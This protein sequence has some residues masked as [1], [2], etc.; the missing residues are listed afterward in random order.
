MNINL[1]KVFRLRSSN[2]AVSL[3]VLNCESFE[4]ILYVPESDSPSYAHLSA[5]ENG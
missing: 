3:V 5:Y 1:A 2:I 4:M